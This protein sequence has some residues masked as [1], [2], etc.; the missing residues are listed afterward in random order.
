[1]A[2][3][4]IFWEHNFTDFADMPC[5]VCDCLV[6]AGCIHGC[7]VG[8]RIGVRSWRCM[9]EVIVRT[10]SNRVGAVARHS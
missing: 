4:G 2:L 8:A 10:R 9:G 7:C 3:R 1:V 5:G 6:E